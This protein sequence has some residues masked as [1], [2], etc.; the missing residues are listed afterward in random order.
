MKN[1]VLRGSLLLFGILSLIFVVNKNLDYMQKY[2]VNQQLIETVLALV[3][4]GE[5]AIR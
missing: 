3:N 2:S 4:A 5:I 1:Q